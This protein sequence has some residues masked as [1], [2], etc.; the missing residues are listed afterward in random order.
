MV[1]VGPGGKGT[2]MQELAPE[3]GTVGGSLRAVIGIEVDKNACQALKGMN[4]E[5]NVI[6]SAMGPGVASKLHQTIQTARRPVSDPTTVLLTDTIAA[7]SY[8]DPAVA[9]AGAHRATALRSP[10]E[11]YYAL[12]IPADCV[13]DEDER[14]LPQAA[15][16]ATLDAYFGGFQ[17]WTL[18]ESE[19]MPENRIARN[20]LRGYRAI[21]ERTRD[22]FRAPAA[23][24]NWPHGDKGSP[25]KRQLIWADQPMAAAGRPPSGRL[26]VTV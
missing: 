21:L 8:G 19:L 23:E 17:G 9:L 5:L 2:F 16:E 18:V 11:A 26:D 3:I 24:W 10:P 22:P 12:A 1:E 14:C 4:E 6:Q 7:A 13:V 25:P 15:L 20:R